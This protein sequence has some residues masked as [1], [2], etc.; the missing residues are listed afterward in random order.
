MVARRG[1]GRNAISAKVLALAYGLCGS[2]ACLGQAAEASDETA[3]ERSS[4]VSMRGARR[5][6]SPAEYAAGAPRP[7]SAGGG[8]WRAPQVC[9][10]EARF[11]REVALRGGGQSA[12]DAARRASVEVRERA[13]GEWVGSVSFEHEGRALSREVRGA[14][15]EEVVVAL[16][17][18]TSLWSRPEGVEPAASPAEAR[19]RA[20]AEGRDVPGARRSPGASAAVRA[21]STERLTEPPAS[22]PST[23]LSRAPAARRSPALDSPRAAPSASGSASPA[24]PSRLGVG[25]LLGFSSEPSDAFAARLQGELW[26]TRSPS[27]WALALAASFATGRH[28]DARLGAARLHLFQG[29]V[30]VCPSGADL[31]AGWW[32]RA[33]AQGRAG[34]LRF[35]SSS[36]VIEAR[37]ARW[38]PWASLGLSLQAGLDLSSAVS[39]RF[40]AEASAPLIRDEFA[41]LAASGADSPA[42]SVTVY[43]AAPAMLD[44]ATG[45]VHAF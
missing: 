32:L 26:G 43:Q 1:H 11:R 34:A 21:T 38:R 6:P 13:P 41:V 42:S 20:R 7:A 35:S 40:V 18:I 4:R 39:L 19:A 28:T 44:L 37:P 24:G 12:V 25:A 15:C 31:G 36:E 29:Q 30:D 16:A 8:A 5:R 3:L 10:S 17:L 23:S 45:V 27:S 9:P 33:C 22:E 2:L 14:D